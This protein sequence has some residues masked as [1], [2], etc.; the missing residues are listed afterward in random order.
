MKEASFA[1]FYVQ[2]EDGKLFQ[3]HLTIQIVNN[4]LIMKKRH[5]EDFTHTTSTIV[6]QHYDENH[7]SVLLYEG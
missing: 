4:N 6:E 3:C 5:K 7:L 1:I 2:T